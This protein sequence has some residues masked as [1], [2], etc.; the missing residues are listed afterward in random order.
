MQANAAFLAANSASGSYANSAFTAANNAYNTANAS[1]LIANSAFTAS[2][3]I[4]AWNTA[5][6]AFSVANS[7]ASYAN[8]AFNV[9]NNALANTGSLVTSNTSTQYVIGNT[10]TSTS[11]TSGA[12][13]VKGGLGVSSNV[14]A[15]GVYTNIL[16]IAGGT[17]GQIHYQ[18]S[19]NTTG[20]VTNGTAGQPLLSNG[21]SAP[22]YGT[23]N[24]AFGGT[25]TTTLTGI[26]KGNGTNAFTV[27]SA[28]TD[29]V[30]PNSTTTFAATQ[31]FNGTSSSLAAILT[32]AAEVVTVSANAATGTIN[33]YP[34]TQSV[35]YYT[36]NA[37]SNWTVN[38]TFS[39]GTTLNTAMSTGQSMTM[40][41]LATQGNTAYYSANVQVD[42]TTTG[43]TTKWQG[44]APTAGNAGG[45]DV[46][47]YTVIKTGSATFTV[48]ASLTQFI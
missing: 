46:Y 25:G 18:T 22:T 32:N 26:L 31:S 23:L 43:V 38:L 39:S 12:L 17:A 47:T 21:S 1:F 8:S 35:L 7:A 28:G 6:A 14:Y 16:S 44:S 5:N 19:A 15:N 48:L 3:G 27:A 41:F 24:V 30:A 45:I 20:F 37:S 4:I 9:A 42:G 13:V 11:N 10:T 33:F 40:A 2:N 34:S 29:Y 36:S